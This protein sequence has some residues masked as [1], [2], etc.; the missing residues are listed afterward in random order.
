MK[1]ESKNSHKK[2]CRGNKKQ[3]NT[4]LFPINQKETENING[5]LKSKNHYVNGRVKYFFKF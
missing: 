3:L 5:K 2:I 4:K 1:E